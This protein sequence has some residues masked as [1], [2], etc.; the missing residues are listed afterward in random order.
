M[1]ETRV[2]ELLKLESRLTRSFIAYVVVLFAGIIWNFF[3]AKRS[4][5]G[6]FEP[7]A[8]ALVLLLLQVGIYIWYAMSA[9][10]AAK[11]LGDRGWKYV[12][13]ILAAPIL[14]LVPI[15]IV[16]MIIGVSPLSIKFLLGGQ[17]QTA[18]REESVADLHRAG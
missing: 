11:S 12:V 4:P 2:D 6:G 16:S 3:I 17:L 8:T 9:G 5:S 10:A 7:S 1:A 14:A 13:W 18:I 15:P